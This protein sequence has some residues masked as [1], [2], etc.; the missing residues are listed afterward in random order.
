MNYPFCN[1][2]SILEFSVQFVAVLE[3]FIL[4][5]GE[6]VDVLVSVVGECFVACVFNVSAA[7]PMPVRQ[8]LV[9]L[10]VQLH[11]QNYTSTHAIIA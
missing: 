1:L 3:R 11:Y 2:S 6:F 10:R 8:L 7:P 5:A 9:R 4:R